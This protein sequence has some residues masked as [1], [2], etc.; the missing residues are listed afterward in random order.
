MKKV[1]A[2]L[3]MDAARYRR[4]AAI[5]RE[6]GKEHSV[7]GLMAKEHEQQAEYL[8]IA[9]DFIS[10][11]LYKEE[12]KSTRSAPIADY[13]M[14]KREPAQTEPNRQKRNRHYRGTG[15]RADGGAC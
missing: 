2:E 5:L 1:I 8:E 3:L 9:A 13:G 11:Q 4:F 7:E 10:A 12:A 15:T 6:S 14:P